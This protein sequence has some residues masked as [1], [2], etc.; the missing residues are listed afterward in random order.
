MDNATV[1]TNHFNRELGFEATTL[2]TLVRYNYV[3]GLTNEEETIIQE[4]KEFII[5]IGTL[6]KD[7]IC[8]VQTSET[9]FSISN[10][11]IL[12]TEGIMPVDEIQ[13][14]KNVKTMSVAK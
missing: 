8:Q 3:K 14:W 12:H 13:I 2:E 7:D 11:V 1:W 6:A 4:T 10:L 9:P 5:S